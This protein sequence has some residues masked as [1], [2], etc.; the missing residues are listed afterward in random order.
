MKQLKIQHSI[1]LRQSSVFDC[2]NKAAASLSSRVQPSGPDADGICQTKNATVS[3][4][5][6]SHSLAL[7]I[8][9][10]LFTEDTVSISFEHF[11]FMFL[12]YPIDNV[13]QSAATAFIIKGHNSN[14]FL[15]E[16][17]SKINI[18]LFTL[19]LFYAPNQVWG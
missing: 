11:Q 10:L 1:N 19:C 7:K 18:H 16:S 2:L 4:D 5:S 13:S 17:N 3:H 6:S 9:L 12:N 14:L 15:Q 8:S